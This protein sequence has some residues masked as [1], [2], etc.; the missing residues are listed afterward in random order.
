VLQRIVRVTL[1]LDA[2]WPRVFSYEQF[3]NCGLIIVFVRQS[4]VQKYF[5]VLET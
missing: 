2:R 4:T 5:S 1:H 3:S